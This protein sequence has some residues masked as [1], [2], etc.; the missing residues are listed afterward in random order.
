MTYGDGCH[1]CSSTT[2]EGPYVIM[3]VYRMWMETVREGDDAG[4]YQDLYWTVM[5]TQT[6]SGLLTFCIHC[7]Q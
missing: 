3:C 5:V 7:L 4:Y 2:S 1:L 6:G